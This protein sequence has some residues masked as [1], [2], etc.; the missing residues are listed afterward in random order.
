MDETPAARMEGVQL[1][2]REI[3][4]LLN[5]DLAVTVGTLDLLRERGDV[6]PQV[7]ALLEQAQAGLSAATVHV[8]QLQRVRRVVT[9]ETPTGPA[10]DLERSA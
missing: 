4:H 3:A 1:A 9:R 2:A 10:L 5:N 7:L 6:S 8:E